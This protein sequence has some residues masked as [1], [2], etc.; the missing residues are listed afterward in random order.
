MRLHNEHPFFL[1]QELMIMEMIKAAMTQASGYRS[2]TKDLLDN[3]LKKHVSEHTWRDMDSPGVPDITVLGIYGDQAKTLPDNAKALMGKRGFLTTKDE[4]EKH[5]QQY[6]YAS[7]KGKRYGNWDGYLGNR[8][9]MIRKG[10]ARDLD[11]SNDNRRR[12]AAIQLRTIES[13][14][15]IPI[16]GSL[17][18]IGSVDQYDQLSDSEL[19]E[20]RVAERESLTKYYQSNDFKKLHPNILVAEIDSDE[21]G[22]QHLQTSELFVIPDRYGNMSFNTTSAK[23]S[24][25]KEY[26]YGKNCWQ[27]QQGNQSKKLIDKYQ[28]T[29][30]AKLKNYKTDTGR[31]IDGTSNKTTVIKGIYHDTELSIL[32]AINKDVMA[33]HGFDYQ[34]IRGITTDSEQKSPQAYKR[35]RSVDKSNKHEKQQLEARNYDLMA[36]EERLQVKNEKLSQQQAAFDEQLKKESETT[37]AIVSD[38]K[39]KALDL[40]LVSTPNQKIKKSNG[41]TVS[42][43]SPDGQEIAKKNPLNYLMK[44]ATNARMSLFTWI[45]NERKRLKDREKVLAKKEAQLNTREQRL[46]ARESTIKKKEDELIKFSHHLKSTVH[47]WTTSVNSVITNIEMSLSHATKTNDQNYEN[48]QIAQIIKHDNPPVYQQAEKKYNDQ[49]EKLAAKNELIDYQRKHGRFS[50]SNAIGK[51]TKLQQNWQSSNIDQKLTNINNDFKMTDEPKDRLKNIPAKEE[52]K[53]EPNNKPNKDD[54]DNDFGPIP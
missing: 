40:I 41:T 49:S 15:G 11:N 17:I 6:K 38:Q 14:K 5:D 51:L 54:R 45:S 46:K 18:Y 29:W 30:N 44:M 24:L 25:L 42:L 48:V 7:Q 53:D 19:K 32:E 8:T 52:F 31:K 9:K 4:I 20:Y 12:L 10:L 1:N 26:F 34:R 36:R 39:D 13:N 37:T 22:S 33:E 47:S 21:E 35:Q 2:S 50:F 27:P 16:T 3:H 23:E 43:A 28:T